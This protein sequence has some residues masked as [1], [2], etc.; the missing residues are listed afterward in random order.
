MEAQE[1]PDVSLQTAY[2]QLPTWINVVSKDRELMKVIYWHFVSTEAVYRHCCCI[3]DSR[4]HTPCLFI[5]DATGLDQSVIY[6]GD[7]AAAL[8]ELSFYEFGEDYEPF[9]GG[10]QEVASEGRSTINVYTDAG[11]CMPLI[12]AWSERDCLMSCD[13]D[14]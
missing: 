2:L 1:M 8:D 14:M 3:M 6:G 13:R 9:A 10:D 11:C 7:W 4:H 12:E 5:H